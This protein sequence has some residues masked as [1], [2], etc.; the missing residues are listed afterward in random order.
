MLQ[1]ESKILNSTFL[2]CLPAHFGH[3]CDQLVCFLID[4]ISPL[5]CTPAP[6][7]TILDCLHAI[8]HITGMFTRY[9]T[10]HR[11][12]YT[13]FYISPARYVY[14]LFYISLVCLHAILHITGMLLFFTLFYISPVCYCFLRYSTYHWYV[15]TLF[16]ISLVCLHAILHITGMFTRYSTYHRYVYTLFY[17]S[18]VCLH[19]ILHITVCLV[20][21]LKTHLLTWIMDRKHACKYLGADLT[22][23]RF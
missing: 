10:Y 6:D 11:Y 12:V 14:T 17:I 16:Y 18:L 4:C 19:A 3:I 5:D 22:T 9:S 21:L 15:Y 1:N 8:L 20:I 2:Q 13:L 7:S 23:A